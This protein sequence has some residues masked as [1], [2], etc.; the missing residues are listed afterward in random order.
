MLNEA[1]NMWGDVDR[2]SVVF[3]AYDGFISRKYLAATSLHNVSDS[4]Y[5]KEYARKFRY[6]FYGTI[7][8]EVDGEKI[9][10]S[11]ENKSYGEK[12]KKLKDFKWEK[13]ALLGRL[14]IVIEETN[15]VSNL[16]IN[17][18]KSFQEITKQKK[19]YQ[20]DFYLRADSMNQLE[21]D[22]EELKETWEEIKSDID[23][24]ASSESKKKQVH[25]D[26]FMT[27]DGII[28]LKDST[29]EQFRSIYFKKDTP[30]DFTKNIPIHRVFKTAMNFMKFLFHRNY[31][32]EEEHD[33]F[34]PASN[35]HPHKASQDFTPIVKHQIEAFLQPIQKMRRYRNQQHEIDSE[36]VINYAKSFVHVSCNNGI[37]DSDEEKSQLQSIELLRMD[38][39]HQARHNRTL[40]S[41][42]VSQKNFFFIMSTVLAFMVAFLKILESG[43]R[44]SGQEEI[45]KSDN[46]WY[47]LLGIAG[48]GLLG[49]ILLQLSSYNIRKQEFH[50]NKFRQNKNRLRA[51]IF[52]SDSNLKNARLSWRLRLYSWI[53][54]AWNTHIPHN[55][56]GD[57]QTQTVGKRIIIIVK[58][59]AWSG[60]MFLLLRYLPP[61]FG[62]TPLW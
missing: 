23:K 28:L 24:I 29:P 8:S 34:L 30:T 22:R 56:E 43:I 48:I 32:H 51:G 50:P 6:F 31:H 60:L 17:I 18:I 47:I 14:I 16:E 7:H 36:G 40:I 57:Y 20:E 35:L 46:P 26:V 41:S 21:L 49:L 10:A 27:R 55:S 25:F 62:L 59:L 33:T 9:L 1:N 61:M 45:F 37:I 5:G 39:D 4:K 19:K 42:V 53:Q 3:S 12:E 2:Y 54:D 38:I 44:I 52:Y 15:L 58:F 13:S 11:T